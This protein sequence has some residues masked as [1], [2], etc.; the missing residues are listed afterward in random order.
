MA[1]RDSKICPYCNQEMQF[2]YFGGVNFQ[3]EWI[4]ENKKQRK[5]LLGKHTGIPLNQFSV[6]QFHKVE[7]YYCPHCKKIVVDTN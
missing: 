2:G 5:T 7:A 4:P 1:S 3:L 6:F